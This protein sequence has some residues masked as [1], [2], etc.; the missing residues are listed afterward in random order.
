MAQDD[1]MRQDNLMRQDNSMRQDNPMRHQRDARL[2]AV[3]E[4]RVEIAYDPDGG[5]WF[6]RAASLPGL[7][8]ETAG[9]L[10][11]LEDALPHLVGRAALP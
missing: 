3:G 11:E 4:H 6:I 7:A 2:V 8:G 1:P 9:T 5:L 10:G